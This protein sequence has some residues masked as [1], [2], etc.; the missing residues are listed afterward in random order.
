LETE[1][2]ASSQLLETHV[3]L[4]VHRMTLESASLA[5]AQARARWEPELVCLGGGGEGSM[6]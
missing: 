1:R 3:S 5:R 4:E 2:R 6:P